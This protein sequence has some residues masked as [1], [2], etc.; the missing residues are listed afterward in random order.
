MNAR[1]RFHRR[2]RSAIEKVG[3]A[4]SLMAFSLGFWWLRG[5]QPAY[6]DAGAVS[7]RL[8]VHSSSARARS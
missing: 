8:S 5:A 7:A 3:T 2:S 4:V 6:T 1:A